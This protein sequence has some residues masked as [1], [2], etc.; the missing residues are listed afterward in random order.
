MTS[1]EFLELVIINKE[2]LSVWDYEKSNNYI[3]QP[4]DELTPEIKNKILSLSNDSIEKNIKH[5]KE[6]NTTF[7]GDE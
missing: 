7:K 1:K 5:W 3:Y 4:D 6:T 2:I